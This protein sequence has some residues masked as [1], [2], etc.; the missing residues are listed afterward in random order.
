MFCT[1]HW[2]WDSEKRV[3]PHVTEIICDRKQD[4][5]ADCLELGAHVEKI[6][7]FHTVIDFSAYGEK[8]V[9]DALELLQVKHD[10]P[11]IDNQHLN[12]L[13]VKNSDMSYLKNAHTRKKKRKTKQKSKIIFSN[14]ML[15][16]IIGR[17]LHCLT[18]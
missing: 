4:I 12:E 18:R 2:Y 14:Q 3:K 17:C 16:I 15:S 5:P 11:Y 8:E 10:W 6:G 9:K 13:A 7:H 1:G